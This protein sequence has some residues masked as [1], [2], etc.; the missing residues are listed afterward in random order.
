MTCAKVVNYIDTPFKNLILFLLALPNSILITRLLWLWSMN[1]IPPLSKIDISDGFYHLHLTLKSVVP[2]GLLLPK[3]DNKEQPVAK[4][5][6]LHIGWTEFPSFCAATKMVTDLAN[7][8]LE[9]LTVLS[10]HCLKV[11]AHTLPPK[12][13]PPVNPRVCGLL[14][15]Y[16]GSVCG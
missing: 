5:L 12:L 13:V 4:K 10:L 16:T 1:L 7:H 8:L 14:S 9:E 2:L 11:A 3:W 15:P 6:V